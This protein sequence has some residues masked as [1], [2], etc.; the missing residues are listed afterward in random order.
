MY[1]LNVKM[2]SPERQGFF[3]LVFQRVKDSLSPEEFCKF[4]SFKTLEERIAFVYDLYR[5]KSIF[6]DLIKPLYGEKNGARSAEKREAGNAQFYAGNYRQ[7]SMMY[8]AAVFCANISSNQNYLI[9]NDSNQNRDYSLALANRSACFQ[10]AKLYQMAL[11]DIL[12]ALGKETILHCY[13]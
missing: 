1:V 2:F 5:V 8:S 7:A 9:Q 3:P 13:K 6:K 4:S 11:Q 10:R 12:L